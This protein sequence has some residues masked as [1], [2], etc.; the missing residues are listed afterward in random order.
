MKTSDRIK[1]DKPLE[2]WVSANG[3]WQWKVFKFYKAPGKALDL[4]RQATKADRYGRV[5]CR[6]LSPFTY[7]SHELKDVY[8]L[9]ILTYATRT[10]AEDQDDD[11]GIMGTG[12]NRF[13]ERG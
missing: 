9:D 8:Y 5:F 1:N 13:N 3:E 11:R 7:G 4:Q 12:L 6:V 2:I 10:F